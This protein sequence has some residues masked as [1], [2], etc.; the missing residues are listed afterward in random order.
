MNQHFLFGRRVQGK[1][2]PQAK[3]VRQR[4]AMLE[5]L[6]RRE[7]FASDFRSFDGTGN[8]LLHTDWGSTNENFVRV[9]PAAYG[10]GIST[11]AGAS[12]AS[13]RQISNLVAAQ[14]TDSEGLSEAGLSAMAYAWGQ[15]LDH[16]LDLTL[17]ASPAEAFNVAVPTGDAYFDPAGT[18]TKTIPLTRSQRPSPHRRAS[19]SIRLRPSSTAR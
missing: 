11:P 17:S 7:V 6:E 1:Y 10:D 2:Q 13:A 14:P 12:R 4:L 9:A 18:G 5:Q 8:N 19:N 16:D 3:K 15:F